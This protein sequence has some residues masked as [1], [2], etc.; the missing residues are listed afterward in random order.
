LGPVEL[1]KYRQEKNSRSIDGVPGL[2]VQA[3]E[4]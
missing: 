2:E 4:V 1:D 3:G